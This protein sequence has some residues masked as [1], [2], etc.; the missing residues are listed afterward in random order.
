MEWFR[1]TWGLGD[2]GAVLLE[3]NLPVSPALSPPI[4]SQLCNALQ[5]RE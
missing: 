1:L 2:L 5:T 4:V 3:W